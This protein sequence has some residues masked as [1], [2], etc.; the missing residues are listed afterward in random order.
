MCV[1]KI[2]AWWKGLWQAPQIVVISYE[3]VVKD[4]R[5]VG[6][7]SKPKLFSRIVWRLVSTEIASLGTQPTIEWD[8][9]W[10]FYQ[11]QFGSKGGW[12]K[13][14]VEKMYIITKETIRYE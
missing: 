7:R 8:G 5:Q 4:G 6:V 14:D 13:W 11:I 12:V 2:K 9:E 10:K 1:E 3:L